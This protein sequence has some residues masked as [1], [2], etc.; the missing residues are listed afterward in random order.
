MTQTHT[1]RFLNIYIKKKKKSHIPLPQPNFRSILHYNNN[2]NNNCGDQLSIK[3]C[4]NCMDK[5][6]GS[7]VQSEDANRSEYGQLR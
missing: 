7:M 2:N 3:Y 1:Y 5:A 4:R 6:Y